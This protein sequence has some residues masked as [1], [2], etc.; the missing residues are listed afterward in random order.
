MPG[1]SADPTRDFLVLDSW[2]L[3]EWFKNRQPAAD[4][5]QRLIASAE[6]FEVRL[7]LSSVNMG[8]VFYNC[9]NE[10]DET[11]ANEALAVLRRLPIQVVHPTER[12]VL[13]AARFKA[14]YKIAYADCFAAVLAVETMSG[15]ATGDKDFLKMQ[16]G[17]AISVEWWGA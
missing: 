5:F 15:V 13:A 9:W 3:M 7:L 6:R 14:L 10:W 16:Q 2:P 11:R 4:R 8:E 12:D 17:G 1:S